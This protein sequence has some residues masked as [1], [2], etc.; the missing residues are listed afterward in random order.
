M[1]NCDRQMDG[2]T[3]HDG[4][5][6]NTAYVTYE[7]NNNGQTSYRN[8]IA[9]VTFDRLLC[10]AECDLLAKAKFL[11]KFFLKPFTH[12]YCCTVFMHS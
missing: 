3:P 7:V 9:T 5:G 4:I 11:V 2:Q 8:I 6:K 12:L 10:D 1:Y